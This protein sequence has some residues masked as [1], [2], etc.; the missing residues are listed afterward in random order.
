MYSCALDVSLHLRNGARHRRQVAHTDERSLSVALVWLPSQRIVARAI[1]KA[2]NQ[3]C[4]RSRM[5]LEKFSTD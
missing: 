2:E 5:K 4:Q 3:A 1:E